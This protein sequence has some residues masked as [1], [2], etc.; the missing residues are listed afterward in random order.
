MTQEEFDLLI[1][2]NG[3]R[4]LGYE[5]DRLKFDINDLENAFS[6]Y[7][8]KENKKSPGINFGK[9]LLQDLFFAE[10]KFPYVPWKFLTVTNRERLIV[11]TVIQ[12][13]GTNCGF[14]FLCGV[15]RKAG[16]DVVK[17]KDLTSQ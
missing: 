5:T 14:A 16:Y 1:E 4:D 2:K 8:R 9:G 6:S 12:W 15:L 13:L 10:R 3:K 11:A 7:W 17:R